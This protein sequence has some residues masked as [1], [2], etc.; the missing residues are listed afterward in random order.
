MSNN[1]TLKKYEFG[2]VEMS[3]M[4]KLQ[5]SKDPVDQMA[6]VEVEDYVSR[7]D[8]S[9]SAQRLEK[10]EIELLES[11]GGSCLKGL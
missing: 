5:A 6:Y 9:E 10:H 11:I 7:L 4:E 2:L 1:E 8:L 3:K